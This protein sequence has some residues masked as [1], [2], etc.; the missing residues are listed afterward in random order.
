MHFSNVDVAGCYASLLVGGVCS[1]SADVETAYVG[2]AGGLR[3]HI[4]RAAA[5]CAHGLANDLHNLA[6]TAPSS[7]KVL[8][9]QHGA[10]ST[11]SQRSEHGGSQSR[12]L[13][14][15]GRTQ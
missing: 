10:G 4:E 2:D 5:V 11:T 14:Q 3:S 1:P 8:T 9:D 12:A 13:A 7:Q 15:P 6:G